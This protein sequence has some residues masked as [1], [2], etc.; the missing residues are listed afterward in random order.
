MPDTRSAKER[1][2]Q[3]LISIDPER[4][5]SFTT[6]NPH[7]ENIDTSLG[8][9]EEDLQ[10]EQIIKEGIA[11]KEIIEAC[12][13]LPKGNL[14]NAHS[15][16]HALQECSRQDRHFL[17][18][19]D[20]VTVH[21]NI[22][23][24]I[25]DRWQ[26]I[27]DADFLALGANTDAFICFEAVKGMRLGAVFFEKEDKHPSHSRINTI[28]SSCNIKNTAIHKLHNMFGTCAFL[29]SPDGARKLTEQAFPLDSRPVEIP[30]LPH[31][32]LGVSFDRRINSVLKH[33]DARICI[34]F[35]A[36]TPNNAKSSR[37]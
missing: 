28:L 18:L 3:R 19:E 35:L 36:M 13:A 4:V 8:A 37:V 5:K 24:F 6:R 32:L 34:P 31:L 12:I 33:I 2:R 10:A 9:K 17:I 22:Y 16:F 29:V 14:G 25:R 30:L 27:K 7:L 1:I 21:P 26:E 20:D 15:M 23:S 11:T